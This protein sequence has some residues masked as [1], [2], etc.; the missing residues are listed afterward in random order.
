MF[1]LSGESNEPHTF[2]SPFPKKIDFARFQ[3][4]LLFNSDFGTKDNFYLV[5]DDKQKKNVRVFSFKLL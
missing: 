1:V 4:E 2:H 3:S 5:C